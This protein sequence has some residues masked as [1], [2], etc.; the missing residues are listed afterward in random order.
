MDGIS[1]QPLFRRR[2][3]C[4]WV[5]S[6]AEESVHFRCVRSFDG[7]NEGALEILLAMLPPDADTRKRCQG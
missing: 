3:S 4:I 7:S 2:V 1:E 5:G 6:R